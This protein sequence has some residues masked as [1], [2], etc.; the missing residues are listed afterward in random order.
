[1][2]DPHSPLAEI[3]ASLAG[4]FGPI[5]DRCLEKSAADR[6]QDC[7]ELAEDLSR[8]LPDDGAGEDLFDKTMGTA[9]AIS[10]TRSAG[11]SGVDSTATWVGSE[12]T[13]LAETVGAGREGETGWSLPVT[14]KTVSIVGGAAAA[15]LILVALLVAANVGS[16]DPESPMTAGS[17]VE[18]GE[19][20]SPPQGFLREARAALEAGKLVGEGQDDALYLAQNALSLGDTSAQEVIDQVQ[21]RLRT[22]TLRQ[23]R[24]ATPRAAVTA[25]EGFLAHF[26]DD[27]QITSLKEQMQGRISQAN[28]LRRV[29]NLAVRGQSALADGNLEEAARNF[30]R[31]LRAAPND[32]Y[33]AHML[34]KTHAAKGDLAEARRYLERAVL[35]SPLDPTV[36]MDLAD[37]L[38]R[39]DEYEAAAAAIHRAIGVSIPR[40]SR[41]L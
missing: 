15:V 12:E 17:E 36:Q 4:D 26:P 22:Q 30:E 24:N 28:Q 20:V 33:A 23:A 38:E 3:D 19:T 2:N 9:A 11:S 35:L 27:E 34:G 37:A 25:Y 5:I 13:L 21:E 40:Q 41:G 16:E 1:M 7:R 6:Y 14:R 29:E 31:I 18:P 10:R 39:L 32:S 8:L